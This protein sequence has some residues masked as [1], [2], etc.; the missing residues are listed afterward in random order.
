MNRWLGIAWALI[1]LFPLLIPTVSAV[2]PTDW[3]GGFDVFR[4]YA[5]V[6]EV[7]SC[8]TF[9]EY[10][11]VSEVERSVMC[12]LRVRGSG[13]SPLLCGHGDAGDARPVGPLL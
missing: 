2:A 1:A 11:V 8:G 3:L 9:T 6:S 7:P 13:P 4:A 5:S 12:Y 10:V